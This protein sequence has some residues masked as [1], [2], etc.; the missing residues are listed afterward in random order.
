VA[1]S[2]VLAVP[3]V[4]KYGGMKIGTYYMLIGSV[5]LIVQLLLNGG[6]MTV[7][8]F[9]GINLV[10]AIYIGLFPTAI[11]WFMFLSSL[12]T[13]SPIEASSFKLLIPVFAS[14][15]SILFLK[16]SLTFNLVIGGIIVLVSIYLVQKDTVKNT[17]VTNS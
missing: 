15:F 5:A 11:T 3:L 4:K 2:S 6:L 7:K 17:P 14:L 9:S 1:A 10:L 8:Q 16:E 12:K 13:L